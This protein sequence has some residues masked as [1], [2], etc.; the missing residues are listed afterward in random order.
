M[1]L[2]RLTGTQTF[3]QTEK[4]RLFSGMDITAEYVNEKGRM[5]TL[6]FHYSYFTNDLRGKVERVLKYL[7]SGK[8]MPE[9]FSNVQ[10]SGR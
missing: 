2:G 3:D 1:T 7:E 6:T 8:P 9:E 5:A 10:T 4:G